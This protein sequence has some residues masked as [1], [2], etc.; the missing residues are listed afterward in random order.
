MWTKRFYPLLLLLLLVQVMTAQTPEVWKSLEKPV[1]FMLA[2]DLGRNGYYEQ[3][4]IAELMGRMAETVDIE[5]VVAAGDVHHFEGVRSTSDP[6]WMTNYELVYSHPELMLPWYPI[7]GNHEYRGNTQA[8]LDYAQVSRRWCMP[9]RY[10]AKTLE[11]NSVRVKLILLDTA[12]L[13]DKYRKDSTDYPDAHRQSMEQQLEWLENTLRQSDEDWILVIGHHP[14]FAETGKSDS[15]RS[16]MQKR[17]RSILL[18]YPKVAMY[19]C[20]HI[21][22]FQHIR[23]PGDSIDY[24][25]N[26]SA[27]LSRKVKPIEGTK[28]CSSEP[29]FSLISADK[30]ELLLRMIDKEG[31]VIYTIRRTR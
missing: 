2:N 28:F 19:L 4:P 11:E 20:G 10:Y 1:N 3:K 12:P 25:V 17:V 18:R 14:I 8:V 29:G 24:V 27:S 6:L 15:E 21:H 13:I 26:S 23:Q 9:A 5:C 30:Q 16:D 22:N 7:L 31:K